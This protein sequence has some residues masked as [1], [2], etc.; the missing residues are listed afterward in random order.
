MS[1]PSYQ[2]FSILFAGKSFD[3]D[4]AQ[5]STLAKQRNGFVATRWS[6]SITHVI[7]PATQNEVNDTITKG[8]YGEE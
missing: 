8:M 1:T 5:L 3:N 7:V 4:K 6:K 2:G